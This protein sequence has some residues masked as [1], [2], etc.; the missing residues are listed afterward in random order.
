MAS[1]KSTNNAAIKALHHDVDQNERQHNWCHL[2]QIFLP[3]A[4]NF[5]LGIWVQLVLETKALVLNP[6]A[7][8]KA[9]EFHPP[10]P[11]PD[12]LR[13]KPFPSTPVFHIQP[14][15]NAINPA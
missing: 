1:H 14:R 13:D 15:E 11:L 12:P 3:K 6:H 9:K 7:W 4:Q 10:S 2:F 8:L 5:P